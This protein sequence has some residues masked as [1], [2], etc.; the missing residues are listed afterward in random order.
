MKRVD[1]EYTESEVKVYWLE[2]EDVQKQ[3]HW[4]EAVGVG[5]I[6]EAVSMQ[7]E[8]AIRRDFPKIMEGA[9]KSPAGAAGL[10]ISMTER[11]LHA[12]GGREKGRLRLSQTPLDCGQ[13]LTGVVPRGKESQ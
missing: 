9:V 11:Q 7:D 3:F 13:V 8:A 1:E 6:T 4:M 12:R 10:L 5:S 2:V